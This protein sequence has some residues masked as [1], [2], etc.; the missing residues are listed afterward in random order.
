M[1]NISPDIEARGRRAGRIVKRVVKSFFGI[2]G[3]LLILL[4]LAGGLLLWRITEG[5]LDITAFSHYLGPVTLYKA[6]RND[7]KNIVLRWG[8]LSVQWVPGRPSQPSA[9]DIGFRGLETVSENGHVLDHLSAF[10]FSLDL[11]SL[12]HGSIRFLRGHL[13][14]GAVSLVQKGKTYWALGGVYPLTQQ[15]PTSPGLLKFDLSSFQTLDVNH[16]T[17]KLEKENSSQEELVLNLSKLA[18]TYQE[19][20]GWDGHSEFFI[21]QSHGAKSLKPDSHVNFSLSVHP[22][23]EGKTQWSLRTSLLTPNDYAKWF[24]DAEDLLS[25]I[26]LPI[27]LEGSGLV[28]RQ[29]MGGRWQDFTLHLMAGKGLYYQT[30]APPLKVEQADFTFYGQNQ[31]KGKIDV[32]V[33]SGT[34]LLHDDAEQEARFSF[35]G[36]MQADD[37]L[38]P[39]HIKII[40][41]FKVPE[42]D[43]AHLPSVWPIAV[44]EGGRRWMGANMTSGIAENF[45]LKVTLES[46][47]GWD[48]LNDTDLEG[49]LWGHDLTVYWLKPLPPVKHIEAYAHFLSA[50]AL[51]I[52]LKNGHMDVQ[53]SKGIDVPEGRVVLTGLAKPDQ[54]GDIKLDLKGPLPGF[55]TVLVHPRLHLLSRYSIPLSN[56]KGNIDGKLGVIL[57]LDA[58]VLMSEIGFNSQARFDHVGF[59]NKTTGDVKDGQGSFHVTSD[60]ISANVE[61]KI[62]QIPLKVS[63]WDSFARKPFGVVN[64]FLKAK[65]DFD[66]SRLGSLGIHVPSEMM[67]GRVIAKAGYEQKEV[68]EKQQQGDLDLSLDLTPAAFNAVIWKKAKGVSAQVLAHAQWRNGELKA[69]DQLEGK[70][71][72]LTI[73]GRSLVTDGEVTGMMV[74]PLQI[75]RNQGN[76]TINWPGSHSINPDYSVFFDGSALDI[77]PFLGS[78]KPQ[79]KE[80]KK[81]EQTGPLFSPLV[82]PQ[83]NWAVALKAGKLYYDRKNAF[84][85]FLAGAHWSR[86]SLQELHVSLARPYPFNL[87]VEDSLDHKG[88]KSFFLTSRNLG[89]TLASFDVVKRLEGGHLLVKGYF[90]PRGK[91]NALGLG[92]GPFSGRAELSNIALFHP[93]ALLK[94]ATLLTPSQWG[95]IGT[96]R[97]GGIKA[98]VDFGLDDQNFSFQKGQLGNAVLG[99]RFRG[100]TCIRNRAFDMQGTVSPFFSYHD[101]S[102]KPLATEPM[103]KLEKTFSFVALT[104]KIDGTVDH[105]HLQISPFSVF[106]PAP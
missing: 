78:G 43:F 81:K 59:D 5:P 91:E 100:K 44:A 56:V 21:E 94:L 58:N 77:S 73:K 74:N 99:G 1:N 3:I 79:K 84:S 72:G 70:G 52:D 75:G 35:T 22:A 82:L 32:T 12:W 66:L 6:P 106:S 104:Y 42:L 20:K 103:P 40:F 45:K 89:A 28:S 83:G 25:T 63:Y 85:T 87:V 37:L 50:D 15:E 23:Q 19:K 98:S 36:H 96:G 54:V 101:R 16:V 102:K 8:G 33:K 41:A 97:L 27:S 46:K 34:L 92:L 80:I 57:P 67:K 31:E 62:R 65:A 26:S 60:E 105:P 53:G 95:Q 71:P 11:S 64:R 10:Q 29:A 13:E 48:D 17:V 76:L 51:Q 61:M 69:I 93:P 18:V 30:G 88:Q 2:L 68:A 24:P 39:R 49:D 7:E 55:L 47:T 38:S 9:L 90:S 4:V 14:G 86:K